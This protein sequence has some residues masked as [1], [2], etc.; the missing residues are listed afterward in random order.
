MPTDGIRTLRRCRRPIRRD[1]D[2]IEEVVEFP[3]LDLDRNGSR[4]ARR[5]NPESASVEP[6]VEETHAA[7]IEEEDLHGVLSTTEED[8]QST[9]ASIAA[10]A[11]ECE[12][13]EPIE[14]PAKVDRFERDEHFDTVGDHA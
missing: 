8:E 12:I 13:R 4:V 5:W 11:L 6:L 3:L 10:D 2:A 1:L 7:A 9:S 14:A